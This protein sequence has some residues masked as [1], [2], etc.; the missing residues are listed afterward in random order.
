MLA[1]HARMAA[2]ASRFDVPLRPEG[3]ALNPHREWKKLG[4][5]CS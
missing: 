1:V 3:A 2:D 4:S 5:R